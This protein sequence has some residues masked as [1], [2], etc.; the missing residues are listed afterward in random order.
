MSNNNIKLIVNNVNDKIAKVDFE[1]ELL[2]YAQELYSNNAEDFQ[3]CEVLDIIHEYINDIIQEKEE[4]KMKMKMIN[5]CIVESLQKE[6][7]D[8]AK[9]IVFSNP[10]HI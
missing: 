4:K 8:N 5:K 1:N 3:L 9:I 6:Y 2:K 10:N 7:S